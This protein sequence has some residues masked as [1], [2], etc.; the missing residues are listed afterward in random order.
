MQGG[1]SQ[2]IDFYEIVWIIYEFLELIIVD[3][4]FRE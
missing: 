3:H 4:Y 1:F 2:K